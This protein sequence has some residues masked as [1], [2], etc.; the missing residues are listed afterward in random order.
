MNDSDDRYRTMIDAIPAMAWSSLPDGS[1]EFANRRWHD[2]TGIS[3]EELRGWG[4]K[5]AVHPDDLETVI[6][7][8]RE[9]L[10]SPQ[11][12]EIEGRVS[13]STE[14][15]DGSCSALSRCET[16]AATSSDGT[17]RTRI[18]RNESGPRHCWPQKSEPWR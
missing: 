14:N 17:E 9:L 1:V 2:Y 16:I 18:L 3:A 4:W 11:P 13:V 6:G 7:K 12:G 5:V 15:I 8:W 10:A